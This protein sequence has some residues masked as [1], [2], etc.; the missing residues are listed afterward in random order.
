MTG[1]Y[2]AR[3]GPGTIEECRA[4]I[5]GQIGYDPARVHYHAGW[6]QETL[7]LAV[8]KLDRLAIL[9]LDADW[10]AST[11]ICLETLYPLVVP[12]GVVIVDDYGAYDGCRQA[13]DEFLARTG[14]HPFLNH[15]DAECVYWFRES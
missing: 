11:K 8:S 1:I 9:R 13:V 4:L 15:V 6:F 3:G 2:D 7:P 12:G 10:Y 5:E 14:V